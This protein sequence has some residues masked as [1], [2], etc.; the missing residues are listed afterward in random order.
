[1]E[2]LTAMTEV[3]LIFG[4]FTNKVKHA[5]QDQEN[6]QCYKYYFNFFNFLILL[7]I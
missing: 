2:R 4:S 7:G 5:N 6:Q 1:M 3:F